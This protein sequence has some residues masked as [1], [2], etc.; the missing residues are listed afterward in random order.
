MAT[1]EGRTVQ[2]R[3]LPRSDLPKVDRE[4]PAEDAVKAHPFRL[5][6]A[7]AI[8]QNA[9]QQLFID[10]IWLIHELTKPDLPKANQFA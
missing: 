2:C 3:P 10:Q 6:N 7:A 1:L 5:T 8:H 4:A 9:K